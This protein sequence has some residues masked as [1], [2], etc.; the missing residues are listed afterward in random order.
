MREHSA[1]EE[2]RAG[3]EP[4]RKGLQNLHEQKRRTVLPSTLSK[5]SSGDVSSYKPD[6]VLLGSAATNT[7]EKLA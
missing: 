7:L 6:G 3:G 4:A 5:Y 1:V 2:G